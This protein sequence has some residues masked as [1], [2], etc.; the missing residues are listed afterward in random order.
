MAGGRAVPIRFYDSDDELKRLFNAVNGLVFPVRGTH[1]IIYV[2]CT[3]VL[4][5]DRT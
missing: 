3:V 4:L 5:H 2:Y 1:S